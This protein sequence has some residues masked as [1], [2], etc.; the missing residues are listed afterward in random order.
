MNYLERNPEVTFILNILLLIPITLSLIF[1]SWALFAKFIIILMIFY[2][3]YI[4]YLRKKYSEKVKNE[5]N[6]NDVKLLNYNIDNFILF[7]LLITF[8]CVFIGFSIGFL[9]EGF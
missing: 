6:K 1:I 8:Y 5:S 2:F 9:F 3:C 4:M 7:V